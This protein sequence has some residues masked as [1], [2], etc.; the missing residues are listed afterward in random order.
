MK[1]LKNLYKKGFVENRHWGSYEVLEAADN[2]VV[3]KIVILPHKSLSLQS[4]EH[5]DECWV[6][7]KGKVLFVVDDNHFEATQNEMCV[8]KKQ[9]KHRMENLTDEPAEVIELQTGDILDEAD[10]VRYEIF[11]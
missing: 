9:H 6:V 10:I 5:R 2:Y 11:Q 7:A 8:V 3:K 1:I 4:H